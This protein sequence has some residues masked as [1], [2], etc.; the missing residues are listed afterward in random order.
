MNSIV[1]LGCAT[2]VPP[3]MRTRTSPE[4]TDPD[5]PGSNVTFEKLKLK[6]Q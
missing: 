1:R 2:G 5:G 4:T 3:G 6:F